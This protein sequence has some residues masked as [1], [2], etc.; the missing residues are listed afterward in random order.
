[1]KNVLITGGLGFIGSH[2]CI[3]LIEN[4]NNIFIIDSLANSTIN[5]FNNLNL[6]KSK[7]Y[8]KNNGILKFFLGDIRDKLVLDKIFKFADKVNLSIDIVIHLA[9]LK[10]VSDS[11]KNPASYWDINFRGTKTLL[12]IMQNN[13]CFSI[14][15]SSSAT[16]YGHNNEILSEKSRINPINTYGKTKLEVEQYLEEKYT[17]NPKKW[18][19]I[20]LRYFNPI[21]AHDSG[22]FGE[23]ISTKPSNLFPLLCMTA[24]KEIPYLEIY[25]NNWN[26]NDGTAI[27]DYVHVMDI[28]KGHLYA[29]KYLSIKESGIIS[30]NL[31]SGK[32]TSI[33]ELIK[34][35]EKT[36]NVKIK[37]KFSK[38]RKGDVARY[39]ASN[40]LAK[41]I[42]N[43]EVKHTIE[44]MC[45][46]GWLWYISSK[47]NFLY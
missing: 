26:T 5:V 44:K 2:T 20:N 29:M 4:E 9:G 16:I 34:I 47:N 22:I 12:E 15:F 6:I 43:W 36:N 10:S 3:Q 24:F 18:N 31:G 7:L 33:L 42:L 21:G 1:M 28:A 39:V 41:K 11:I 35:F 23:N 19:I 37:Y 13:N 14:I 32:G 40:Y 17:K 46:D 25:G 38:R 27:R 45:K 30:I 8:P